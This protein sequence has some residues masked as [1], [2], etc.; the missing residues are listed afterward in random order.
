MQRKIGTLLLVAGILLLLYPLYQWGAAQYHQ[1]ALR[2]ELQEEL[3]ARAQLDEDAEENP[4]LERSDKALPRRPPETMR[5]QIPEIDVSA[6]VVMGTDLETLA[7][8]PG[9]YEESPMPWE[10]GG[11]VAIAGHRTTHGAWFRNVDQLEE[12]D[13]IRLI[14]GADVYQYEVEEVFAVASN[15]W[16]VVEPTGYNAITLTT[17]HPPGSAAERLV[18]RGR[19][20]E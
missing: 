15:D 18:V 5:I 3:D 10:D 4:V 16:S 12:G 13:L 6:V 17:C 19:Q 11:N 20:V 1:H 14:D 8:G 7:R 9:F 2:Q